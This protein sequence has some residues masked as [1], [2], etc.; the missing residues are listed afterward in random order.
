MAVIDQVSTAAM[1][2][3]DESFFKALGARLA[4]ARN[5]AGMSQVELAA[6]LD[7]PQQTLGR[8][9]TG[10]SR[11][12]ILTLMAMSRALGFSIDDMLTASA[13]G[14]S[15]RGPPSKL[16]MQMEAI[17]RLPKAKQRVVSDMLDG[18]LAQQR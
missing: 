7:V 18:L 2:L 12:P 10:E 4:A 8:Y 14:R 15:K 1:A 13:P 9:E 5:G 6:A 17:A 3:K 16:E 11:V